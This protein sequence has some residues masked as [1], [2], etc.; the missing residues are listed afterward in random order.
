MTEPLQSLIACGTQLWLDSVDPDLVAENFAWG[1]TGATSNPIIVADLIKSGRFDERLAALAQLPVSDEEIA[2]SLTDELVSRAEQVFLP[3]WQRT[4]GDDGYVSFELDPLIEDPQRDLDHDVRV[5]RYVE[6]G[7]HWSAGHPNRM[8]KVPATPAGIDALPELARAG[9]PLNVTLNFSMR[10]Y[11]AARDAIWRGVQQRGDTMRFKSVFSIFVSRIDVY[12]KQNASSLS[13]RAQGIVGIVNA[14]RI[15]QANQEFWRHHPTPLRQ[16]IVFA[17]TGTKNPAESPWKYVA[18]L[19]GAD[20]QTNPPATNEAVLQSGETFERRVDRLPD[21]DVLA[22]IDRLVDAESMERQ[23]MI[24]GID[25]FVRPQI[26]LMRLIAEKRR[27]IAALSN[28]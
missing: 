15:W 5:A 18:A 20:I 8:I 17:S 14:Q 21:A 12:T 3:V 23:L 28:S 7:Q 27:E 4:Q 19:A 10:Q 1:A 25:K 6:L 13:P 24:E 16:Q 2:W 11:Q 22:E 26:E 9:V